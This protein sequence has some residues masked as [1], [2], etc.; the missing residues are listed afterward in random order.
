MALMHKPHAEPGLKV[1]HCQRRYKIPHSGT[2]EYPVEDECST[3]RIISCSR[4]SFA[5]RN[6]QQTGLT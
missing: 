2:I 3:R 5:N 6:K 1:K 4:I